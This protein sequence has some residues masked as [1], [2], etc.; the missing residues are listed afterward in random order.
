MLGADIQVIWPLVVSEDSYE[1]P[2]MRR[3]KSTDT[4]ETLHGWT[5]ILPTIL[6]RVASLY[7]DPPT[8]TSVPLAPV[9]HALANDGMVRELVAENSTYLACIMD[10]ALGNADLCVGEPLIRVTGSPMCPIRITSTE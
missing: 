2:F 5:G 8:Y 1:Y 10:I 7:E 3:M 4:Q 9:A 6:L